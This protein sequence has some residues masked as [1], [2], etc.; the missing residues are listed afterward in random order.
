M[1]FEFRCIMNNSVSPDIFSFKSY[2][3]QL[4]YSMFVTEKEKRGFVACRK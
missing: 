3:F 1:Q 2:F 4:I